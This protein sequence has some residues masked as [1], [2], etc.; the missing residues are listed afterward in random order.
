MAVRKDDGRIGF[1]SGGATAL[2]E[3]WDQDFTADGRGYF[4]YT[5]GKHVTQSFLDPRKDSL[6]VLCTEELIAR[7]EV[8]KEELSRRASPLARNWLQMHLRR[9]N[10]VS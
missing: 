5:K 9:G 8:A 6:L 10:S 3:D 2:P 7:T 4:V 1:T